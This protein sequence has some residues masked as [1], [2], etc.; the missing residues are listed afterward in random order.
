MAGEDG[1]PAIADAH[2]V[3]HETGVGFLD[4]AEFEGPGGEALAEVGEPVHTEVLGMRGEVIEGVEGEANGSEQ[5]QTIG[6]AGLDAAD[7]LEHLLADG[8]DAG[9]VIGG[10]EGPLLFAREA[11]ERSEEL[12]FVAQDGERLAQEGGTHPRSPAMPFA[13]RRA[14]MSRALEV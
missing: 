13:R 3:Q 11:D 2:G 9:A 4:L 14:A 12:L 8:F 10:D 5:I 7:G 6:F 1:G